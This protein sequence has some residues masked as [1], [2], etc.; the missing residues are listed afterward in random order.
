MLR[1]GHTLFIVEGELN[2]ISIWQE[3]HD[4]GIQVLSGGSQH[5][6]VQ[7]IELRRKVASEF[8]HVMVWC[9]K[10][11]QAL[12]WRTALD[13]R[14]RPMR[15]QYRTAKG[16]KAMSDDP[17]AVKLDANELLRYSREQGCPQLRHYLLQLCIL[18]GAPVT[19]DMYERKPAPGR[20]AHDEEDLAVRQSRCEHVLHLCKRAKEGDQIAA[21]EAWNQ[22]RRIDAPPADVVGRGTG[23]RR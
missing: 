5:L 18:I 2:A 11:T 6:T 4:L 10:D 14:G 19:M 16:L 20:M 21:R 7:A 1:P 17:N 9:D 12:S 22:L 13:K 15:S 3:C 8:E 23:A